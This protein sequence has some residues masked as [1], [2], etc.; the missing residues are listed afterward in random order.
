MAERTGAM[1]K[2]GIT[3]TAWRVLALAS[4]VGGAACADSATAPAIDLSKQE[5][6]GE[7]GRWVHA[8]LYDRTYD[9]RVPG[10]IAA[11]DR[12]P[13]LIVLHGAGD[14]GR[15]FRAR[16]AADARTDQA[17]LITVYPDGIGGEWA[18]GCGCTAAELAGADDV[19]F[20]NTLVR[21]L[22]TELPVDT[23]RVYVA[24]YSQGAQLAQRYGCTS[25]RAPA[26]VAAV[27]GMPVRG[28]AEGCTPT[29]PFAVLVVHGDADPV[30]LYGGFGS[31]APILS[32][33]ETIARWAEVMGCALTP[34]E[35]TRADENRDGTTVSIAR[36]SGCDG[37]VGV[38][39][40]RVE[41]GGH[42]WPGP[43]GPWPKSTGKLSRNLDATAEMIALFTR[44]EAR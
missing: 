20:L 27:A 23:T 42:T 6:E 28:V 35:E 29:A 7:V 40:D 1:G 8:G 11:G 43:T 5:G 34:T 41:G 16:I 37:G 15:G 31:G 3:T 21:Q 32:V 33:P 44:M 13:L 18:T 10:G 26:G 4:L 14:T 9:L 2:L 22:A 38:Q 24:G 30:M 19:A 12:R 36:Y 17:G 25:A 39:L